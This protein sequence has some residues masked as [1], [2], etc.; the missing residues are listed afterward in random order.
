MNDNNNVTEYLTTS[1][2]TTSPSFLVLYWTTMYSFLINSF[3]KVTEQLQN[4]ASSSYTPYILSPAENSKG[5][6]SNT[7]YSNINNGENDRR[8]YAVDTPRRSPRIRSRR[9][10]QQISSSST[11]TSVTKHSSTRAKGQHRQATLASSIPSTSFPAFAKTKTLIL[12]LDETLI[13][14]TVRGS[15][16]AHMLEV[17]VDSHACLYYVHKRPHVD[18]FLMKVAE[19]YKVVIFTASMPEYADPVIDWLDPDKNLI[20]KR[21]F[22]QSCIQRGG[23]YVKDL[24][25]VENDL[26]KVCL[27]DNSSISYSLHQ[28]N[29]IPIEGWVSDPNDEALLDLLPFLDAL[30]F[31]EDEKGGGN[32][33]FPAL[34]IIIIHHDSINSQ[35]TYSMIPRKKL[36]SRK[37]TMLRRN[38]TRIHLRPEDVESVEKLRELYQQKKTLAKG[39]RKGTEIDREIISLPTQD[40]S[41]NEQSLSNNDFTKSGM[42]F[43][44]RKA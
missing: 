39:K 43:D 31:T 36:L 19:W 29:G 1:S 41:V 27:I 17:M 21:F 16:N 40:S 12:D 23:T 26:S 35:D 38:P 10:D 2:P 42:P 18:Y 13:H 4:L 8:A 24:T 15:D 3:R 9:Q 11:V 37:V 6:N 7:A 34:R 32:P 44:A 25:L 20:T 28:E 33:E 14:S 30:R 22:R 5:S